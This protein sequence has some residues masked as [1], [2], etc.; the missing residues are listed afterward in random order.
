MKKILLYLLGLIALV[1]V[2]AMFMSKDMH[3]EKSI[4]I[5]A[6]KEVVW[7]RI[8]SL[9]EV[10]N[11]GP[12]KDIDPKASNTWEGQNGAIGSKHCWKGNKEV[13]EGCQTLT[14]LKENERVDMEL[15]FMSPRNSTAA[16]FIT[17]GDDGGKSKVTWGFDSKMPWPFNLMKVFM[18]MDKMMGPPFEKGL[19]NLKTIAETDAKMPSF[20]GYRIQP[21]ESPGKTFLC[22]RK[23]VP[24]SGISQF[25][26]EGYG[27]IVECINSN[28]LAMVDAPSALYYTYDEKKMVTDM[29]A[30]IRVATPPAKVPAGIEVVQLPAG[31]EWTIDYYGSYDKSGA[32]H[33]AM[34][35]LGKSLK[36][37]IVV[38]VQEQYITDPMVEKDTSKW[39]TKITYQ[40]K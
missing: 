1:L 33:M 15:Q 20:G 28:K 9:N 8:A 34:D 6:P 35:E 2:A 22:I 31:K 17:L 12:W 7:K 30:A 29:C 26:A 38:P 18:N 16:S 27:K 4:T 14:A 23:K 5:D 32:A 11:W 37:Q 36:Q 39:L 13:G 40:F 25:L 21:G 10:H 19:N 24:F 3:Y